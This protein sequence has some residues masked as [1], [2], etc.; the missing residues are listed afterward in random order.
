MTSGMETSL[1]EDGSMIYGYLRAEEVKRLMEEHRSGVKNNFKILF[2]IAVLE[3]WLRN[4]V[5]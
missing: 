1:R 2:S 4:Y 5:P 3:E